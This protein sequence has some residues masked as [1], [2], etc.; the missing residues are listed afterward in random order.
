MPD[1]TSPLLQRPGAV[2]LGVVE[3]RVVPAAAPADGE[4]QA[5]GDG[6]VGVAAH[7]GDP[8]G[9]QRRLAAGEALVDLSHRGVLTVTG[10]DRLSWLHSLTSQHLTDLL[11]GES[12]ETLVLTP[13]GHLEHALHL[14][15]D[16]ERVWITVEPASTE[17]L[18]AW[19]DSMR[20]MLRVEVADVTREYAVVATLAD[21]TDAELG[22]LLRL[23]PAAIW[24][25]PWPAVDT[26]GSADSTAA[27]GEAVLRGDTSAYGPVQG[28]P[29]IGWALTEVVI[30]RSA[31]TDLAARDDLAWSGLWA[32][33]ALRIAAWR[34]RLGHETDHRTIA[35]E[36]DWLRTG[37]HLHKGCYRGQETIARVHNLGRP[38]R[39]LV[40]LHL[41]GSGHDLP[42]RG[43]V[44]RL[45]ERTVG[46]ITSVARHYEDG[47]IAL[48]LVKRNTD[49]EADLLVGDG[50]MPVSAAQTVI[51]SA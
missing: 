6:L 47:P 22:D 31:L 48:A 41:D 46:H 40:F 43:A 36:V 45:G 42:V 30:P 16:G 18:R 32:L 23:E 50:P 13:K 29:G 5:A 35:H 26:G 7:Y 39:R 19:L 4:T 49:T 2:D 44:V 15:D 38:P 11:P 3:D 24:R 20:F 1:L 8:M 14:V 27:R 21:R 17:P 33:E 9:E 10:P 25:D 37:V 12:A 51:V 34:P 28:H